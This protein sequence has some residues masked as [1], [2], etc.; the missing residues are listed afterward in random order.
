MAQNERK[1]NNSDTS[2][3]EDK[4]LQHFLINIDL[5]NIKFTKF[6]IILVEPW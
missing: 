1:N 4:D 2:T 3:K 6:L 5:P